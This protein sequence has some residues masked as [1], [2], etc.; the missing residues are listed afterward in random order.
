MRVVVQGSSFIIRSPIGL[1]VFQGP[2]PPRIRS[3]DVM[4][5]GQAPAGFYGEAPAGVSPEV[6][7]VGFTVYGL[8]ENEVDQ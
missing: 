3:F 6:W 7:A 8:P 2:V 1:P 4:Y 5:A